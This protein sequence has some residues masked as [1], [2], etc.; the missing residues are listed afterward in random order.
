MHKLII[1]FVREIVEAK[2]T[3]SITKRGKLHA[4]SVIRLLFTNDVGDAVEDVEV[5]VH[6]LEKLSSQ[7]E[8]IK[9]QA[10]K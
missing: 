1:P 4:F 8:E 2:K 6:S 5:E 7:K 9:R 3:C 10:N